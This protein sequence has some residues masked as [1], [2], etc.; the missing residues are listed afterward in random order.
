MIKKIDKKCKRKFVI[1]KIHN[2]I[3]QKH[4]FYLHDLLKPAVGSKI[5][6]AL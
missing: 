2:T 1:S 3:T 6:A 4:Y 5:P